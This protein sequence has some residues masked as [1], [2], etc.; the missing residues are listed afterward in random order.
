VR[1]CFAR[2]IVQHYGTLS[3]FVS[4]GLIELVVPVGLLQIAKPTR[5]VGDES[6]RSPRDSQQ[7][8]NHVMAGNDF[9]FSTDNDPYLQHRREL[10]SVHNVLSW[11]FND[12]Y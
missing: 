9:S 7:N 1:N 3:L 12:A 4:S 6:A 10:G 5:F 2:A 8:P 11:V